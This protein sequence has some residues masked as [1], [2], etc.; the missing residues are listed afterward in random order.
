MKEGNSY[1]EISIP[2]LQPCHYFDVLFLYSSR[3]LHALNFTH[4]THPGEIPFLTKYYGIHMHS[5]F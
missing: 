2:D 1:K 5:L 3:I 4:L